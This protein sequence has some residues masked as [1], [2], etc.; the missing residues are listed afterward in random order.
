MK[1]YSGI[2]VRNED[3]YLLCKRNYEGN[4]PGVWSVPGGHMEDNET[5]EECARLN[6]VGFIEHTNNEDEM[7]GLMYVYFYDSDDEINPDL[8]NAKDGDEHLVC[9]YFSFDD[10]PL[11]KN[12]QLYKIIKK[13]N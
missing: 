7:K 6:L 2:I 3:K 9:N 8:R 11:E 12:D 4:L 1:R 10:L 5:P 13:L